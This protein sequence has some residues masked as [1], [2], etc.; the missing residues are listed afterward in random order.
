M[1]GR[2]SEISQN[3]KLLIS[4]MFRRRSILLLT[5]D[6]STAGYSR[7]INNLVA[8]QEDGAYRRLQTASQT[9]FE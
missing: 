7:V 4:I 2:W 9:L 5:V 8:K 6:L 3:Y 1:A